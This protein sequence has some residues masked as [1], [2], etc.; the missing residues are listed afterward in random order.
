M[1]Q[2]LRENPDCLE[3]WL[4]GGRDVKQVEEKPKKAGSRT[5]GPEETGQGQGRATA[6]LSEPQGR[7]CDGIPRSVFP[8]CSRLA[9]PNLHLHYP[10]LI[11]LGIN[12]QIAPG[13]MLELEEGRRHF[14]EACGARRTMF[15]EE[16]RRP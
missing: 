4:P 3:L 11:V 1:F 10:F 14:A 9:D 2:L 15:D 12:Y 7:G 13:R 6:V 5:A 8:N 16:Q